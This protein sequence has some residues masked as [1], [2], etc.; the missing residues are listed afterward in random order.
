MHTAPRST[1]E[2]SPASSRLAGLRDKLRGRGL[3]AVIVRSTDA[4]LNEYVPEAESTRVWLTG[5]TGSMGDGVVTGDRAILVVDGRYTLQAAREAPD[6]EARTVPLGT[7]IEQGWLALFEELAKQGVKRIGVETDR[8]P[9]SL[10]ETASKRA[11]DAGLELVATVPSLIEELR[12]ERGEAPRIAAGKSWAIEP[13]LTGRS[14]KERLL[15]GHALLDDKRLDGLLVVALDEI[16]WI[17]NLRGDHFPY[18]ATFRATA[19][20][21]REQVLVLQTGAGARDAESGISFADGGLEGAV[22][23]LTA[24]TPGRALRLGYDGRGAPAHVVAT[25]K[26]RG[27][28]LI[29]VESPFAAARTKKTKAELD[30]MTSAFAR[31]DLVHA[32]VKSWLCS[33]VSKGGTITEADVVAK[34]TSLFKRSGAF[35]LSFQVLAA[36]GKHGAII[37]YS[38]PDHVEPIREGEL[39]LLDTGAYYEG[40][41][42]TDLTRTFLVGAPHVK[43]TKEQKRLFTVILKGAI[44]AMRAR[45]PVGATG[46]QLDALVRQPMWQAGL[47]YGHGTGHGV[48]VNVHE[49]PPRVTIGSRTVLEPG[50]VFSIEPGLYLPDFGGIR[51]ENL[52][53]IVEDS[54]TPRDGVPRKFLRVVPLTF[55]PL[56]KRLIDRTLL[57][58][59]ERAFLTWFHDRKRAPLPPLT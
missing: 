4:F 55:S 35:A 11:T 2:S 23:Q 59:G 3:Q 33:A 12:R 29:D 26:A 17:T 22:A 5:F 27:V 45:L 46:E 37:H 13:R 10:W 31:A 18:Q 30:H 54:E 50:Q 42:A 49:S 56:D 57:S 28:E 39:F 7:S 15:L 8:L 1:P 38:H 40:G 9:Q 47:D 36:A 52:C 24:R 41:L 32:K 34:T 53:T 51:I 25:L 44:A 6:F 48:G 14:V 43:A 16:A 19:L 21:T 58:A 20:V